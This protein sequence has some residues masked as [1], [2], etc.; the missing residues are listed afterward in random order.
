MGESSVFYDKSHAT[1]VKV[2]DLALVADGASSQGE[3][4][5]SM[6]ITELPEG[7]ANY[8]VYKTVANGSDFFGNA[9]ALVIGDNTIT[10]GGVA[11]DRSVKIQLSSAAVRFDNLSVNGSQLYPEP[12]V[13]DPDTDGDGVADS[14][15]AFP[16]DPS[17]SV[18]SDNDG[19]GDNADFAPND[20][21]VTEA[22]QP[23]QIVSVKG[24]PTASLGGSV[25]VT[26][27][28]STDTGETGL[29]GL[30]LR[31][32]YDSSALTF[33][34]FADVLAQDAINAGSG[35]HNDTD[36][37][38]GNAATDKYVDAAWASIFGGW[39][40]VNPA[41]I[42]TITFSV[43]EEA[44]TDTTPIDFSKSSTAA[45][46]QFAPEAYDMPFSSGSWDFDEDGKADALTDGLMLLRYTFNL[47]DTAL[48]AGAISADSPLTPAEVEANV[49]E[50]ASSFADI[51]GSGNIDAL[52]DGLLLLRYLF[53]LRD[54]AL[55]AGAIA[56]GAERSTSA[57]VEAYIISLMP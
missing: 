21:S 26:I 4:T 49:A 13:T 37:L 3:K 5:L 28:H 1:W 30:G 19:V 35:P 25:S 54:D 10:I 17:E 23:K 33:T 9:T 36:N 32:H 45:G 43:V 50:A 27:Q 40:G 20:P 55:I 48:T 15:D 42:M 31:V 56:G 8:R 14:A 44:A 51:D 57:D 52:T 24:D 7:G 18:D 6:N 22:P 41:D 39:P 29:T 46:Y 12:V 38:D 16:N 34:E 11:F 53:N 47:R 2:I